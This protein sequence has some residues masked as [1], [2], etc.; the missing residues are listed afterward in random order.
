MLPPP[1]AHPPHAYATTRLRRGLSVD[2][3]AGGA[4]PLAAAAPAGGVPLP[5][6]LARV[7][8]GL[9]KEEKAAAEAV[10][11]LDVSLR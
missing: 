5:A 4:P 7:L 2:V 1:A 3:F 10:T 9:A 11:E 8:S 6:T